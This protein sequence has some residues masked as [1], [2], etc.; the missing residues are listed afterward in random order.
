MQSIAAVRSA[1]TPAAVA[2]TLRAEPALPLL[3]T[4]GLAPDAVLPAQLFA[5]NMQVS[6]MCPFCGKLSLYS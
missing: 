1:A 3:C 2:A 4:R 5:L 6:F